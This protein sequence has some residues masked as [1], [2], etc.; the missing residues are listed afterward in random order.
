VTFPQSSLRTQI[1]AAAVF[2]AFAIALVVY[3]RA[4]RASADAA[5]AGDVAE[6]PPP[7][8]PLRVPLT[9]RSAR[10]A[11]ELHAALLRAFGDNPRGSS[12]VTYVDYDPHPDRVHITFALDQADPADP[13]ARPAALRRVRDLLEAVHDGDMPWTWVL[14]T[15]T[16]PVVDKAGNTA[17]STVIRAQFRRDRLRKVD[18]P[19]TTADHVEPLAEQFWTHIDLGPR[20]LPTTSPTTSP[21]D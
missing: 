6:E 19:N 3:A 7:L 2:V 9:P 4:F 1:V 17:E 20:P 12:R 11:R 21:I 14:V 16:A 13:A 10:N 5:L 8:P 18:W 15:G